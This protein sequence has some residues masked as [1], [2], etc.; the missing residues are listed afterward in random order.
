MFLQIN[1]ILFSSGIRNGL[2]LGHS[3]VQILSSSFIYASGIKCLHDFVQTFTFQ[4]VK[5]SIYPSQVSDSTH[6][7]SFFKES[8]IKNLVS[9]EHSVVHILLWF[10][11]LLFASS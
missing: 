5:L 8:K 3:L 7:Y 9:F 10:A 1:S 4:N 2:S 6:S 11:S